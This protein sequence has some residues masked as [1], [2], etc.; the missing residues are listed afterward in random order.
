MAAP[1]HMY[2]RNMAARDLEKSLFTR[3]LVVM[4][5]VDADDLEEGKE[6]VLLE[7][8]GWDKLKLQEESRLRS[9]SIQNQPALL[10]TATAQDLASRID[11]IS[12]STHIPEILRFIWAKLVHCPNIFIERFLP[13][14]SLGLSLKGLDPPGQR[15][16]LDILGTIGVWNQT[17][18]EGKLEIEQVLGSRYTKVETMTLD[19]VRKLHI[20]YTRSM[21]LSPWSDVQNRKDLQGDL[22]GVLSTIGQTYKVAQLAANI[23]QREMDHQTNVSIYGTA[24]VDSEVNSFTAGGD[25]IIGILQR[26]D[27]DPLGLLWSS[28]VQLQPCFVRAS[29]FFSSQVVSKWEGKQILPLAQLRPVAHK[30]YYRVTE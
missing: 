14:L 28:K 16:A 5:R 21:I 2:H 20:L 10:H 18:N 12:A 25:T 23:R 27:F 3:N 9:S 24:V 11:G 6:G 19:A 8:C 29:V 15:S 30:T 4:W 13:S 7:A 1:V 17:E 22:F 26:R